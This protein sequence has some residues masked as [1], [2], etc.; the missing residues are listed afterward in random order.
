VQQ[1]DGS[2][3]IIGE[4]FRAEG[5]INTDGS[6]AAGTSFTWTDESFGSTPDRTFI[7][8]RGEIAQDRMVLSMEVRGK[9]NTRGDFFDNQED[10]A[11]LFRRLDDRK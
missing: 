4:N 11:I 7:L 9:F 8:L 5:G 10:S 6:F 1:S 3:V 2:I